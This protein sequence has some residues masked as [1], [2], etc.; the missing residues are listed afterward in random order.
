MEG[1]VVEGVGMQGKNGKLVELLGGKTCR[2][3]SASNFILYYSL[4][5]IKL[6][7]YAG[8]TDKCIQ[9]LP[10]ILYYIILYDIILYYIL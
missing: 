2:K 1:W 6:I 7:R 9:T 10:N 8:E 3:Y 4:P 5:Y